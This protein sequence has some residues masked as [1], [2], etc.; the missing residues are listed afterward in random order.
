MFNEKRRFWAIVAIE[1]IFLIGFAGYFQN[2]MVDGFSITLKSVQMDPDDIF[3]GNYLDLNYEIEQYE[4][5]ILK[6]D[7][8][9]EFEDF[10]TFLDFEKGEEVRVYLKKKGKYWV[11]RDVDWFGMDEEEVSK[12]NIFIKAKVKS[13]TKKLLVLDYGLNKV[14][15]SR[16]KA[17]KYGFESGTFD[18]EVKVGYDGKGVIESV[19][20]KGKKI[21]TDN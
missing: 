8:D 5:K 1:L 15:V 9:V 14:F 19:Y 18:V 7:S 6:D 16:Q 21:T 2:I 4:K 17:E 10:E 11:I 20:Y 13:A 12:N 3:R